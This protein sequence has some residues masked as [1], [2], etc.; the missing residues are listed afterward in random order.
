[1]LII[2]F[3][4]SDSCLL[5]NRQ[6]KLSLGEWCKERN[7]N[8]PPPLT[9]RWN[10]YWIRPWQLIG[11]CGNPDTPCSG[12]CVI[13]L[14]LTLATFRLLDVESWWTHEKF[15]VVSCLNLLD[16]CSDPVKLLDDM[17]NAVK[18]DGR[19]VVALVLPYRPFDEF[20]EYYCSTSRN[21]NSVQKGSIAFTV[22]HNTFFFLFR[23]IPD[24][25]LFR[26]VNFGK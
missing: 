8:P 20:S 16:R 6:F 11:I 5:E 23:F 25:F 21:S 7:L 9:Y 3:A 15:D 19:I 10:T 26:V 22:M 13:I 4:Q 12:T 18:P 24:T 2:I 14:L 17:K 1:M